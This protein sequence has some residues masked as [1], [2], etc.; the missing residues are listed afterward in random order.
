MRASAPTRTAGRLYP[1]CS[2]CRYLGYLSAG[3]WR[4]RCCDFCWITGRCRTGLPE[5]EDGRCPAFERGAR[6]RADVKRNDVPLHLPPK[7]AMKYDSARMTQLYNRGLSDPK[8]AAE[9]GCD[10]STVQAWRKRNGLRANV[11]PRRRKE[12]SKD[13]DTKGDQM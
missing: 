4:R 9:I 6:A 1:E 13:R 10:T 11:P 7:N 12:G 8:I 3:N 5:R 2:E